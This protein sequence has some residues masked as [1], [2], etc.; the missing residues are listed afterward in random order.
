MLNQVESTEYSRAITFA[1]THK[2]LSMIGTS[3]LSRLNACCL[4]K[5]DKQCLT[6]LINGLIIKQLTYPVI[7]SDTRSPDK[8]VRLEVHFA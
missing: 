7:F 8:E 2:Y 1:D 6:R 5:H 4:P 3:Q